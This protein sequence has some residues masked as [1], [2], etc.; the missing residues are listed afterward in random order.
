[1]PARR[2]ELADAAGASTPP[3][4]GT[5]DTVEAAS[6]SGA[7]VLDGL[8]IGNGTDFALSAVL[9][10]GRTAIISGSEG[11][12]DCYA[13][14]PPDFP[15]Y[16]LVSTGAGRNGSFYFKVSVTPDKWAQGTVA[17]DGTDVTLWVGNGGTDSGTLYGTGSGGQLDLLAAPT[18]SGD[19]RRARGACAIGTVGVSGIA[20]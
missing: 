8:P 13:P 10:P 15:T 17:I 4:A 6:G 7:P 9:G 11:S 5:T 1:M 12:W 20:S 19:E 2:R 14:D 3:D 18:T 16:D